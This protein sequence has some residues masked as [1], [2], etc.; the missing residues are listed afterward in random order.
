MLIGPI[1]LLAVVPALQLTFAMRQEDVD[2]PGDDDDADERAGGSGGGSGAG[3]GG[4]DPALDI[5][6]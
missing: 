3:P 5:S 1:M 6:G 2:P 4:P